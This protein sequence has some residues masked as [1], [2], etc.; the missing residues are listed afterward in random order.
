MDVVSNFVA[1]L[2]ESRRL[3]TAGRRRSLAA[4]S[5][6]RCEMEEPL[7]GADIMRAGT[8]EQPIAQVL[9]SCCQP[10]FHVLPNL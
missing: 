2:A 10:A 1:Q 5:A 4:I 6:L 7:Y 8:I 3:W 9:P